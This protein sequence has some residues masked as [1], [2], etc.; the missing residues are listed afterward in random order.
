MTA[1]LVTVENLEKSFGGV[2]VLKGIS[3]AMPHGQMRVLI[4]PNGCGKSTFLKT[5]IGMHK[6]DRGEIRVD[7]RKVNGLL[8]HEIS[9]L[10]VSTKL[11]VP[12]IYRELSVYQ[13]V[14]IASQRHTGPALDG[15]HDSIA[16]TL[17]LIGLGARADE[18]AGNLSHGHQQWLEIGMA[19]STHPKLLLLD[20]PTAGMTAEETQHTVRIVARLN[21]VRDMGVIIVEHDMHFVAELDAPCLVINDGRIFF[22]GPLDEVRANKDVREIYFGSRA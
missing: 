4:G 7:G 1:E 11:Q 19:I 20:E 14:R 21:K 9:R 13:N 15:S 6:P 18:M 5:L 2:H 22:E 17:D 16:D 12:S 3:F 10:G 8:P